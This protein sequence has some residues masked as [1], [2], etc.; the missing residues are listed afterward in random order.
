MTMRI[1]KQACLL[2][3]PGKDGAPMR[4]RWVPQATPPLAQ[5]LSRGFWKAL[6]IQSITDNYLKVQFLGIFV[7]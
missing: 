3:Q 7:F 1:A 5:S 6:Q 2:L 4:K